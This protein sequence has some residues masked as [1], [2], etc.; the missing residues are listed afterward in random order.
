MMQQKSGLFV[1]GSVGDE[2]SEL[3]DGSLIEDLDL[4]GMETSLSCLL[5]HLFA[6]KQV[7]IK[8]A[9]K[10]PSPLSNNPTQSD[11]PTLL[12]SSPSTL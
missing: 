12:N 9:I 3:L 6:Y 7:I 8:F 10:S 11:P 5:F 1:C 4:F 2:L